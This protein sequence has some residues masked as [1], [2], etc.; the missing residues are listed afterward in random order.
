M[1]DMR[2]LLVLLLLLVWWI[3]LAASANAQTVKVKTLSED[4]QSILFGTG[5]VVHSSNQHNTV[6]IASGHQFRDYD[7]A[8]VLIDDK[9][10]AELLYSH[11]NKDSEDISII[12]TRKPLDVSVAQL[13]E[14]PPA[15]Q[16]VFCHSYRDELCTGMFHP[17]GYTIG[18]THYQTLGKWGTGQ[19]ANVTLGFSGG[20]VYLQESKKTFIGC[21]SA[22]GH[23]NIHGTVW[24]R[25]DVHWTKSEVIAERLKQVCPELYG[26]NKPAPQVITVVGFTGCSYCELVKRDDRRKLFGNRNVVLRYVDKDKSQAQEVYQQVA[27]NG[28]RV[29]DRYPWFYTKG[30]VAQT[31]YSGF[32]VHLGWLPPPIFAPGGLFG[33]PRH[34]QRQ[35]APPPPQQQQAPPPPKVTA[36]KPPQP[37]LIDKRVDELIK[38]VTALQN[39]LSKSYAGTQTKF[40]DFTASSENT[41]TQ[42]DNLRA[43]I[44][45]PG[46]SDTPSTGV[47]NFIGGAVKRS[48]EGLGKD[49]VASAAMSKFG[50]F[51]GLAGIAIAAGGTLLMRRIGRRIE[52]KVDAGGSVVSTT[53]E[54][55][56]INETRAGVL[57]VPI[58]TKPPAQQVIHSTKYAEV[59]VDDFNQ[60]YAWAR[61]QMVG[62]EPGSAGNL[63]ALDSMIQQYLSAKRK[64]S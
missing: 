25:R 43:S 6:I 44:G 23:A 7:G 47:F 48:S 13:V 59:Q 50:A 8:D 4:H 5:V 52:R 14:T 55:N 56:T 57:P 27:R 22:S 51:G 63:D 41:A 53:T 15:D 46:D 21:I 34:Y 24:D 30:K 60:A 38:Q 42:I 29:P 62:V 12:R 26:L 58:S 17:N 35:Q 20:A 37:Q 39:E 16:R 54:P 3:S 18:S 2:K 49:I 9:F 11:V 1:I 33:P 61:G 28:Q 40:A 31:G 32:N 10:S 45:E 19:I 36:N 64:S